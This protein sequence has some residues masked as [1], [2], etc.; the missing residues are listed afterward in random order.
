MGNIG[1]ATKSISRLKS[2]SSNEDSYLEV[3]PEVFYK[4]GCS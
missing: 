1:T 2:V 3:P 4:K